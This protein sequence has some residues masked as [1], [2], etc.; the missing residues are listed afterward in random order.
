MVF[1]PK[2]VTCLQ[3]GYPL[4]FL[5]TLIRQDGQ[6][7]DQTVEVSVLDQQG[8]W[9]FQLSDVIGQPDPLLGEVNL[10]EPQTRYVMEV[11]E[12]GFPELIWTEILKVV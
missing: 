6:Q 4:S 8:I 3:G 5:V 1:V 12:K 7:A 11:R 2:G 10:G 9:S